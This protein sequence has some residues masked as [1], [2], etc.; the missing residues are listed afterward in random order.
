M[1]D[2]ESALMYFKG[3]PACQPLSIPSSVKS[4][5]R[6]KVVNLMNI[7]KFCSGDMK[8]S[9]TADCNHCYTAATNPQE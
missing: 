7:E 5:N 9:L 6:Q 3:L 8:C 4:N 1:M 2:K